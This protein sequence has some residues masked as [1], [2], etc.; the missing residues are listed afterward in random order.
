MNMSSG[1]LAAAMP[2]SIEDA[3]AA[4]RQAIEIMPDGP[5]PPPTIFFAQWSRSGR[6]H[7]NE[8]VDDIA[9]SASNAREA[10]ADS[11]SIGLGAEGIRGVEHALWH[12]DAGNDK[13][14]AFLAIALG[15]RYLQ[16]SSDGDGVQFR[17]DPKKV[18]A[19]IRNLAVNSPAAR[20]LLGAAQVMGQHRARALRNEVSHT[21]SPIHSLRPMAHLAIIRFDGTRDQMPQSL[22]LYGDGMPWDQHDM[23]PAAVWDRVL[24]LTDDGLGSLMNTVQAA[25]QAL[26]TIGR[27]EPPPTV[28]FDLAT[29]HASFD[30]PPFGA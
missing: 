23:G 14:T 5:A 19:R 10:I 21:L 16:V 8:W 7:L 20:R 9:R 15:V 29:D 27:L 26:P 1:E 22:M 11:R 17:A 12:L 18:M 28:Y 24:R 2:P 25:A 6:H 13:L 4:L 3:V 30:R